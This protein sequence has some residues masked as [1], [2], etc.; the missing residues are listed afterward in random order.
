MAVDTA[1][2]VMFVGNAHESCKGIFFGKT[3]YCYNVLD[4][5]NALSPDMSELI[6]IVHA[7]SDNDT[8]SAIYKNGKA[9]VFDVIKKDCSKIVNLMKL[10]PLLL[11]SPYTK[12]LLR[13]KPQVLMHCDMNST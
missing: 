6:L 4:L 13:K 8:T 10:H 12:E 5:K 9:S 11:S 1:I 2:L 7:M 3:T